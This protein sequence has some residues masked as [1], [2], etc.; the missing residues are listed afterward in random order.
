[1]LVYRLAHP[2]YAKDISGYGSMMVPGRWNFKGH[3]ILYTAQNSSLALLEYLAHTEGLTRRL[4]Y[5]LIT[6]EVPDND[7]QVI[8][9]KQLSATW[10][11]DL[12]KTRE[13]GTK[14]LNSGKSLT[15]QV[16]SVVNEDNCNFLINPEHERFEEVKILSMKEISFDKRLW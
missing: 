9:L 16:P 1:M 13:I 15:L 11:D 2:K 14:W 7:L 5:Q 6:I 3:R 4:P 8:T 10:R 12:I